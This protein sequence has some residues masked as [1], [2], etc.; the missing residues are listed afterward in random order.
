MIFPKKLKTGDTIGLVCTGSPVRSADVKICVTTLED[1][2]YKVKAADNLCADYGGYMAGSGLQRACQLNKMFEDGDVKAVFCLRGGYG[3]SRIMEH[4]DYDT[5]RNNPKIFVGY[6]D[7]TSLHIALNQECGLITFHGPM[8]YSNM[9]KD[10]DRE[11]KESLFKTI[12]AGSHMEFKNPQGCDV[13][14]LKEGMGKGRLTGG[15]LSILSA[16]I[17]TPY[18][19]DTKGKILFIE[20]T[21]EPIGKIEKWAWHLKDA[22]KFKDCAGVLL[23]QFTNIFNRGMPDFDEIKCFF[24]ILGELDIPVLYNIQSGH[25][26]PMMTLPLGAWCVVDSSSKSINF[27]F[28]SSQNYTE[29]L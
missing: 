3:S 13:K 21:D 15:N 9:I 1:M 19:I 2:G 7:V 6:S 22:G 11:S 18:E 10:F 20:E 23:G 29:V 26:R 28:A 14:V 12:N 27:Q 17:G 4:M 24:D 16:S 5:V 25:G 8:V